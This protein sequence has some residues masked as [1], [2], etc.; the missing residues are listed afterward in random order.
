MYAYLWKHGKHEK[1][2]QPPH[3]LTVGFG[4]IRCTANSYA[5]RNLD[6]S[7]EMYFGKL[8]F[9][10]GGGVVGRLEVPCMQ[11]EW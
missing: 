8:R 5:F 10:D 2:N 9:L 6:R 11:S 1:N 7:G 4:N 3:K